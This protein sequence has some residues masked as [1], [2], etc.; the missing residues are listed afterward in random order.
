MVFVSFLAAWFRPPQTKSS[1]NTSV[2]KKATTSLVATSYH[3]Y[4]YNFDNSYHRA[5]R[6]C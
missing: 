5:K 6:G 3:E 2:L 4:E 1:S